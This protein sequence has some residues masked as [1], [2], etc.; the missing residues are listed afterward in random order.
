MG[1]II[2]DTKVPLTQKE[3]SFFQQISLK[4]RIHLRNAHFNSILLI[5]QAFS[6]CYKPDGQ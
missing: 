3:S 4:Q 1:I 6:V 5:F 2:P